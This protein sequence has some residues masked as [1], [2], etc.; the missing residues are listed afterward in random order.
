MTGGWLWPSV[1]VGKKTGSMEAVGFMYGWS[2]L[3]ASHSQLSPLV[4]DP[5]WQ[6]HVV[7][8]SPH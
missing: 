8:I 7:D 4:A 1:S 6:F 3:L 5:A 2:R